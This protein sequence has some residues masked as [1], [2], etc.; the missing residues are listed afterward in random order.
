M[1]TLHQNSR[2]SLGPWEWAFSRPGTYWRG[3]W[4]RLTYPTIWLFVE[5]TL[6]ISV[7]F[8][9]LIKSYS[10]FTAHFA[11]VYAQARFFYI[12][13][14]IPFTTLCSFVCF[15]HS[16]CLWRIIKWITFL[17]LNSL[18]FHKGHLHSSRFWSR[19]RFP[20]W[21]RRRSNNSPELEHSCTLGKF[22]Q[23]QLFP[24]RKPWTK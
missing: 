14:F 22:S 6:N 16:L 10:I 3:P 9:Q 11:S 4:S 7:Y 20:E 2:T 1:T 19:R 15:A 13:K 21:H 8:M 18:L 12:W 5:Q 23:L 17:T 24:D